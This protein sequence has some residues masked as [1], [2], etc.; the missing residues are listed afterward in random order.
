M[1]IKLESAASLATGYMVLS[2]PTYCTQKLL[3]YCCNSTLLTTSDDQGAILPIHGEASE[4][5]RAFCF[6]CQSA[7]RI[8]VTFMRTTHARTIHECG[9][10]AMLFTSLNT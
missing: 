2:V 10:R 9:F 8:K 1:H 6:Y 4:H 5:H 3:H 7:N